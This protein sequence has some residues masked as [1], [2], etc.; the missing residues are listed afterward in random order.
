MPKRISVFLSKA[1]YV[2]FL[3]FLLIAF[4]LSIN[5]FFNPNIHFMQLSMNY[6]WFALMLLLLFLVGMFFLVKKTNEDKDLEPQETDKINIIT[7]EH[8]TPLR[9][10]IKCK[11]I[12]IV[13]L[14]ALCARLIFLL[15]YGE[16][17]YP[18]SDF[19]M[20]HMAAMGFGRPQNYEL[21]SHWAVYSI[22]LQ[23][24][25]RLTVPHYMTAQILNAV[26]TAS[27][28]VVIYLLALNMSKKRNIA[29][30]AAAIFAFYPANII[31]NTLLT[32]EHLAVLFTCVVLLLLS[33]N[34]NSPMKLYIFSAI[35]GIVS[36]FEDSLKGIIIIAIIAYAITSVLALLINKKYLPGTLIRNSLKPLS[37]IFISIAILLCTLFLSSFA[38][39]RTA[40]RILDIEFVDTRNL[41][42][43]VLYIGLQPSGE[44]QVH[45]GDNPRKFLVL[46]EEN[47]RDFELAR[48][49][50]YD[51]LFEQIRENPGQ[52]ALLFPQKFR[53]AWQDDTVPAYLMWLTTSRQ[54]PSAAINAEH[55]SPSLLY[56]SEQAIPTVSQIF[57]MSLIAFSI[58]G[59]FF[60][61]REL[62]ERFNF[63][64]FLISLYC[65][66][67]FL[68][69]LIMEAQSR[70]K[71]MIIPLLCILAAYGV[72]ETTNSITG[73][74][75]LKN[76]NLLK[77][78][79]VKAK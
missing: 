18:I 64:L 37:K 76:F 69:M 2:A 25:Y 35:A 71:V 41:M 27:T 40:E 47:N 53:W 68:L 61:I 62:K 75:L 46:L 42:A 63:G 3:V 10:R 34:K 20:V 77:G 56:I 13:F 7:T 1:L 30:T 55:I 4:A 60:A 74:K 22:I 50:T 33:L 5:A 78:S 54:A 67:F 11:D 32:N 29:L 31:Y 66:G 48:T 16:F 23:M 26:V 6:K 28:A 21:W 51:F 39:G 43:N 9:K 8:Y 14:I 52:F 45:L 57:Y 59:L 65:F 19:E 17:V 79:K 24:L 36:A 58:V 38:I 72:Y 73:G 12:I 70:Y 15:F 44:G 49:K